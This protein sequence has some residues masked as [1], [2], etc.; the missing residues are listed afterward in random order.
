[1]KTTFRQLLNLAVALATAAAAMTAA[2]AQQCAAGDFNRDGKSDIF[3][4]H[5][6]LTQTYEWQMNGIGI[7]VA[8]SPASTGDTRWKVKGIGDFDGDGK[9]DIL[10]RHETDG[11]GTGTGATTI[12]LMN[13]TTIASSGSPGTI[14]DL[15]W[16]VQGV[17]DFDG[18]GKADILWMHTDGTVLIWFMNGTVLRTS[19]TAASLGASSGWSVQGI[20]DFNGDGKADIL[21]VNTNGTV[22]TWLMNGATITSSA[23]LAN[24]GPITAT[25]WL[26]QGVGDFD[27]DGKADIL[28]RN[29][30]IGGVIYVWLM[31]GTTISSAANVTGVGTATGTGWIVKSVGDYDG[32][33]KADIFWKNDLTLGGITYVW[34]MNGTGISTAN[35]VTGVS[36]F[37]WQITAANLTAPCS[38]ITPSIVA[39]R[40]SGVAPLAVFFDASG[41]V[42]TNPAS[43]PFHDVEYR[44]DFGD[45]AGSPVNGTTWS[46][47]TRP[48]VN[49]RNQA[50]GPMTGHVFETPGNYTVTL[51]VVDVNGATA[52]ATTSITVTDP[53]TVFSGTN[54]KCFSKTGNFTGCPSGASQITDAAGDFD[55]A[56][57]GNMA[58][59]R[60]LLFRAGEAWTAST[61]SKIVV[62]GPGT[63]G[64]YGDG[65]VGTGTKPVITGNFADAVIALSSKSTPSIGD[66]RTMD[67]EITCSDHSGNTVGIGTGQN[68][69]GIKQVTLLRVNVH[70]CQHNIEFNPSALDFW[71]AN[72]FIG[73]QIYDQMAVV[74][75]SATNVT[76]AAGGYGMYTGAKR[77]MILGN[78]LDNSGGGEH[79]LRTPQLIDAVISNNTLQHQGAGG[80]HLL[81]LHGYSADVSGAWNAPNDNG[82]G[83][84]AENPN[85]PTSG[86]YSEKIVISDN[87][88][89]SNATSNDAAWSVAIGPQDNAHDERVRDVIF[90][91]N[92][93]T[94]ASASAGQQ[95]AL[96]TWSSRTT[97]RNNLIDM[98]NA[99]FHN[100]ILSE[101]RGIDG[102]TS[103]S[104]QWPNFVSVYNNT[105]YSASSGDFIGLELASGAGHNNT[106][107]NVVMKNN[108]GY[109]PASSSPVMKDG[110]G[111][112]PVAVVLN[113]TA[114]ASIK[115][116][117]PNFTTTPP[118]VVT[119]YKPIC[120]GSTYPCGQG[121]TVPV[122]SDFFRV[123]EP[124]TRDIGAV[125]H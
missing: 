47:G 52:T 70:N 37:R 34:L 114:N 2:H 14:G 10:F 94:V 95:V 68:G 55:A 125:I 44:W 33:G 56:V 78:N 81:K 19:G 42:T 72:G 18:D 83:Q 109:A 49:S 96:I 86:T 13:G 5:N 105:L 84:S 45:S 89:I 21:W 108:L 29:D 53:N 64:S 67:L 90:E 98:T 1:M 88:F 39:A 122:M 54:T 24:V 100:A 9:A 118:V 35:S 112:S 46:Q 17:G 77:F 93:M 41:T 23:S 110:N 6:T 58:T 22:V 80:K 119:D 123:N 16:Q 12:W 116:S 25:G 57:N 87:K 111:A 31:N 27:G 104:E 69:A 8:G 65:G 30:D 115:T 50:S 20:G 113:N 71:N 15:G 3:W 28:W 107:A 102:T 32:D 117:N 51:T 43:K 120:T 97:I 73:Q 38:A 7:G 36:D 99:D 124:A 66:W 121:T 59:N 26:V 103:P 76:G 91:R 40:S 4:L 82:P 101:Q 61:A 60:R 11:S 75:S 48:G 85:Y 106:A 62:N 63:I 79:V 74:D 92:W